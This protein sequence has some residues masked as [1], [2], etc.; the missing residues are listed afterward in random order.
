MPEIN[1]IKDRRCNGG[2]RKRG[3]MMLVETLTLEQTAQIFRTAGV[4]TTAPK[5]ADGIEQG[6]YPFGVCIQGKARKF[7]IYKKK[8]Y[9]Y[10][11]ERAT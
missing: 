10:L 1:K 3:P 5:I 2:P 7:E 6:V 8:V 9:E 4:S 11:N